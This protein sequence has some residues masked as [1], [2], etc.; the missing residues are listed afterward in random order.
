MAA[1]VMFGTAA[2]MPAHA[3]E[4][5]GRAAIFGAREAVLQ[6]SLSPD[7]TRI[8]FV[9]PVDAQKAVILIANLADRTDMAATPIF[10][11]D[12]NPERISDCHWVSNS[13]LLCD[14][15]G[16]TRLAGQWPTYFTRVV[17]LDADGKNVRVLR[18]AKGT[19]ETLGYA[20][21]GG[22]VIDWNTG[23]DGHVLMMRDY[24]PETTIGTHLAQTRE[25]VGVDDIDT[26]SLAASKRETPRD[27][28]AAYISDGA[29]TVRVMGIR[30]LD[31]LSGYSTGVVNYFYRR[32]GGREWEKLSAVDNRGVGFDPS[33]VDPVTNVVY[34]L[35]R[36]DG[37]IAAYSIALDGSMSGASCRS[38][39]TST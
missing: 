24:V 30:Q 11:V 39:A 16:A 12:G 14:I 25:G 13:R 6:A 29:G 8:A 22:D 1:M 10:A 4:A 26:G 34:G 27:N 5:D 23:K 15:F 3:S 19:G 2:H 31:N 37:R 32:T 35:K 36:K 17:A 18:N 7:G 9:Q 33:G 20:L 38:G 21:F 28:V